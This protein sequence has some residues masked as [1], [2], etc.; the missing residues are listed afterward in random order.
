MN[1]DIFNPNNIQM[2]V[3]P[4]DKEEAIR[5]AGGLLVEN[6]YIEK[7]YIDAMLEREST[8]TTYI[9]NQVA[10]PHGTEEG[11][12]YVKTSGISVIQVPEGVDFGDGQTAR[13]VIAIAGKDG[14]HLDILS[15][16]ALICAEE[17]KVQKMVTANTKDQLMACFDG[18]E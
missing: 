7:E 1:S 2:D 5:I 15:K 12:R 16:I 13:M 11:K 8:L 10:I 4:A 14:E 3:R 6:G 9:G 17:E 18:V